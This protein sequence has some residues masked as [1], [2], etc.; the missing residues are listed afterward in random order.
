ML[1]ELPRDLFVPEERIIGGL[2]GTLGGGLVGGAV[3]I[4][5]HPIGWNPKDGKDC[6]DASGF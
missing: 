1:N 2:L 5:M 4:N 6:L 3:G